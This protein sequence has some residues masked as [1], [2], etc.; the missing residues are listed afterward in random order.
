M[1][2]H[3]VTIYHHDIIGSA[4]TYTFYVV[5]GVYVTPSKGITQSG[6][7]QQNANS[8]TITTSK[9][10]TDKYNSVWFAHKGDKVIKGAGAAITKLADLT[11]A[12][13]ITNIQENVCGCPLDNIVITGV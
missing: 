6:H 8:V 3:T 12:Y 4:D 2:P 13:E 1:F 11:D 10:T 5:P 9:E 7:G